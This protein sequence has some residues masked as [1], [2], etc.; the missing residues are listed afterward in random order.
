LIIRLDEA[1]VL[2]ALSSFFADFMSHIPAG[3]KDKPSV[4]SRGTTDPRSA[5]DESAE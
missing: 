2:Q 4:I 3:Q 1:N 5:D